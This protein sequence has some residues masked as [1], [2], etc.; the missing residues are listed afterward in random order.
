MEALIADGGDPGV[1]RAVFSLCGSH[2]TWAAAV[3]AKPELGEDLRTALGGR[4]DLG[5]PVSCAALV[6]G[7]I[8]RLAKAIPGDA[9]VVKRELVREQLGV[10]EERVV[11][12]LRRAESRP[13]FQRRVAELD[14]IV[15]GQRAVGLYIAPHDVLRVVYAR[16]ATAARREQLALDVLADRGS[17]VHVET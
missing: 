3:F 6:S 10:L 4:V 1:I 14:A 7:A 13:A 12:V 5:K 9:K 16:L 17:A 8:D 15:W 11:R 2:V